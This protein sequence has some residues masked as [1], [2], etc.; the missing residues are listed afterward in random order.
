MIGAIKQSEDQNHACI[1]GLS[2]NLFCIL[3]NF[4]TVVCISCSGNSLKCKI[5]VQYIIINIHTVTKS[6]SGGCGIIEYK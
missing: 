1:L 4:P 2:S 3:N 6:F 5:Y